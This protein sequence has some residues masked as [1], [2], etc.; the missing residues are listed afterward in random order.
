MHDLTLLAIEFS[1]LGQDD[2]INNVDDTVLVR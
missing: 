2:D 1:M